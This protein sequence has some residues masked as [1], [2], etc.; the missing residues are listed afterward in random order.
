[1]G[2]VTLLLD[3]LLLLTHLN[4]A[5][6]SHTLRSCARSHPVKLY[7]HVFR[8]Q[9]NL[10]SGNGTQPGSFCCVASCDETYIILKFMAHF[11]QNGKLTKWSSL[12]QWAHLIFHTDFR[13]EWGRAFVEKLNTHAIPEVMSSDL[14]DWVLTKT[15]RGYFVHKKPSITLLTKKPEENQILRCVGLTHTEVQYWHVSPQCQ[16]SAKCFSGQASHSVGV[17]AVQCRFTAVPGGHWSHIRRSEVTVSRYW[18][19]GGTPCCWKAQERE[20]VT[21]C[22]R[23]GKSV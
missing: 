21:S 4:T 16:F 11:I 7:L 9:T 17:S 23:E 15:Q 13:G 3:E 18:Y 5:N 19:F 8:G 14:M 12:T 10:R 2:A 1:M 22:K 20:A 6:Q